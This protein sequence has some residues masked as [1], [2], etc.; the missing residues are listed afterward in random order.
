MF[1][2]DQ[3]RTFT[4]DLTMMLCDLTVHGPG[5]RA[6]LKPVDRDGDGGGSQAAESGL[7]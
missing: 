1:S 5:R 6:R 7:K 3:K 4:Q 2:C